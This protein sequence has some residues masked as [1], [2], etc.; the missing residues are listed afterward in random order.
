MTAQVL[1]RP[2]ARAAIAD[3]LD[4]RAALTAALDRIA[5][6]SPPDLLLLFASAHYAADFDALVAETR[7]RTGARTLAGCSGN[8]VVGSGYEIEDAPGLSLLALWC[9]GAQFHPVRLHQELLPLTDDLAHVPVLADLSPADVRA[10]FVFA[11][12]FRMDVQAAITGLADHFPSIPI[13]GGMASAA[14][15]QRRSWVFF[16]D[17]VYDEGGV[18]IAMTGSYRV[19]PV[20]AQGCDPI[21][22]PWTIT[23]IQRNTLTT[24][25][26]RPAL[27]VMKA[28]IASLPP[29]ERER[30][31]RSLVAGFAA[32]EYKDEFTR[33]DFLVRGVLGVDQEQGTI[34]VGDLPRI[35]QTIQ[36]QIR[37]ATAADVELHQLL[38]ETRAL[39]HG[40]APFAGVLCTCNGRG[41][42]LFGVC[43]HDASA[44]QAAF[45]DLPIA[46]FFCN[47]EIGP[48]GK[49][50][51]TFLHAFTASLFLLVPDGDTLAAVGP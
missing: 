41:K 37:D 47:G 13:V 20:I 40:T 18:A 3:G 4:W 51:R 6:S 11:D 46:G 43:H 21:G 39:L 50:N 30:A 25:S 14:P 27:E 1:S 45:P 23:G 9:P 29:G 28:T 32:D 26:N 44:V 7:R 42:D 35:G 12:P 48:L 33:G 16:D 8:G 17:Q 38:A 24:I 2:I 31:E 36:F 19:L 5:V 34:T 22:E 10:W 49:H 15:N